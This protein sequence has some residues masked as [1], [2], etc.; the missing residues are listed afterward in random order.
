MKKLS[1]KLIVLSSIAF[2]AL[3][4]S[5]KKVLN[6]PA[7]GV[8]S[9]ETLANKPGV[10]GLLIGAYSVVDGYYSGQPNTAWG[11]GI[12]NWTYGGVGADDAYKGSSSDDQAPDLPQLEKHVG[13]STSNSYIESKW[14]V[15]Y[16]GIQRANDVIREVALVKDGSEAGAVG[17]ETIA[18]ARFL[19]G[20]FHFELAKVFWNVPYVDETIS[21]AAGNYDVA[22]AGPIWDKIEAD[23][24]FAQANLPKTQPQAGRANSYAAEAFLAKAYMYDNLTG[25]K[26]SYAKALPLLTDLITNGVTA[27]GAKYAL[28][29][30]ANNFNAATKNQAE[31]V[32]AAQ[33]TVNDGSNGQNDDEGDTLN[34]PGGGTY[35]NCCGFDVPSYNLGNAYK[36]DANGLPMFQVDQPA[37]GWPKYDDVNLGNDHGVAATSSYTPTS[38]AVDPRLDWTVGRRGIPYLDWGLC[39]GEPWT[40]GDLVPYTPKKNVFYHSAQASTTDNGAGWASSQG[41]ADNYNIIRFADVIL[42]RAEAEAE[43]GDLASAQADVNTIRARAALKSNWVTT[44]VDNS[45]PSKGNTT[46][47]AANYVVGLYG[48]AA[49]TSF[50]GNGIEYARMAILTERQLEFGMEGQR[51]F[52]LARI[53]GRLGGSEAAGFMAGV[54]DAY[55]KADNRIANPVLSSAHFTA[56]RDE[57]WP[58]PFQEISAEGGKLKQNPQY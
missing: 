52:D 13:I 5:C 29:P 54:L 41:S 14:Q 25:G 19:R 7:T 28:I 32:F 10:D 53:D 27:S 21:Y 20:L 17:T 37:N 48:A 36:V 12:S 38:E 16:A 50:A 34:F 2:L 33:M 8:L 11:S 46:T 45:D 22:N 23:F 26:H 49:G 43:T 18:E 30:F 31:S 4:Y 35:T 55:Y 42:W 51:F 6:K 40:R 39:G 3:S 9:G 15:N 47:P 44:Y 1:F 58:I 56:G 57:I 24:A